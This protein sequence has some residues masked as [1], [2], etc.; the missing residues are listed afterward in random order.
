MNN[1]AEVRRLRALRHLRAVCAQATSRCRSLKVKQLPEAPP[2]RPP[3][4]LVG[5]FGVCA[6]NGADST[7][8][9]LLGAVLKPC[10]GPR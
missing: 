5:R 7:P 8:R 6:N 3:S 2:A 4:R 9:E 1:Y 10:L